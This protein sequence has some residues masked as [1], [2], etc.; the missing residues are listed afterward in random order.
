MS[1]GFLTWSAWEC[2]EIGDSDEGLAHFFEDREAPFSGRR[3]LRHDHDRFEE[4]VDGRFEREEV[5]K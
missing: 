5:T 3:V 4:P 1:T 2:R